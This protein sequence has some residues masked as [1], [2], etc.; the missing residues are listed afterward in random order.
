MSD[1]LNPVDIEQSIRT[2]ADRI[3]K[4][5]QIVTDAE[6]EHRTADH[7]YDVAFAHAYMH[8]DGPAHEKKYAALLATQE[9]RAES[10][11]TELAYK[12]AERTAKALEAE[13]RAWQ[14]VGASIRSMY[15]AEKGTG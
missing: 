10:D 2:V 1:V 6:Q 7:A 12:H 11:R 3:H 13:L 4:G 9:E 5:V 15:A 14:S 8:H